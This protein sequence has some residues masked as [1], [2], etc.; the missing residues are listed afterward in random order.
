M[1]KFPI[2]ILSD[3]PEEIEIESEPNDEIR[4][5]EDV[6][7]DIPEPEEPKQEPRG[8]FSLFA[9]AISS[10]EP[11]PEP[12]ELPEIEFSEEVLEASESMTD[13][14]LAEAGISRDDFEVALQD[15]E[16]NPQDYEP[17]EMEFDFEE[18]INIDETS[19]EEIQE[20]FIEAVQGPGSNFGESDATPI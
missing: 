1:I 13:E 8:L 12:D 5:S 17:M 4:E 2:Y 7:E 18:D 9:A 19:F 20:A 14:E 6:Q 3:E 16:D 15:M 11:E 10:P